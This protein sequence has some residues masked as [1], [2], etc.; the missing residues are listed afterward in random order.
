MFTILLASLFIQSNL[1]VGPGK[2]YA[3]I[4]EAV[5]AAK[6][7]DTIL[8]YPD[9]AGY[10]RTAINIQVASLTIRG[11]GPK[12]IPIK[13]D[14]F[15]Y[16]G[17]GKVPRAIVQIEPSGTRAK[18]ENLDLSGAHNQS[19]NGAGVRIHAAS[20]V[21]VRDC[22]IHDNDMGIMSN[23]KEG[24]PRAASNQLIEYCLIERNG[25]GKDPG[26]NHNLYLGGTSVKLSHCEIR[27]STTGHNVKSRAHYIEVEGCYIHN[28]ANRE[29]D[30]PEA[31]DTSRPN[32]NAL[33]IGNRIVKDPKCVGNRGVI[34]FGK[35]KG[36]RMGNLYMF[37][38]TIVTPFAS[39]VV[40]VTSPTTTI[41]A[42]YNFLLNREQAKAVL[43]KGEGV[44]LKIEATNNRISMG[45]GEVPGN[46]TGKSRSELFG[47]DPTTYL[48]PRFVTAPGGVGDATWIDGDG[49][50][51]RR[52]R[53]WF[54][55][56][57]LT[58]PQ[59]RPEY[60]K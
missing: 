51:R 14:G 12:P 11:I 39:P 47:K 29:I 37:G 40:L 46:T 45:Y 13:G 31:W 16:S 36:T 7:G 22:I 57:E 58:G 4:E 18:L 33:L 41:L 5:A 54:D 32:S 27:N 15:D 59:N 21:T 30:L 56:S 52:E 26:Y 60:N 1:E 9:P 43:F 8:V 38:N 20:N 10:P 25:N 3:R 17:S 24:D 44:D 50:K 35:E 34:H 48:G 49:N 53:P 2:V 28:A 42:Q 23:G 19:F 6:G 55:W